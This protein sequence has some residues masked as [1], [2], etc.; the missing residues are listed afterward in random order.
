MT[1]GQFDVTSTLF[2]VGDVVCCPGNPDIPERK[3]VRVPNA[4]AECRDL[5]LFNPSLCDDELNVFPK[6]WALCDDETSGENRTRGGIWGKEQLSR[7]SKVPPLIVNDYIDPCDPEEPTEPAN[8]CLECEQSS[9]KNLDLEF[10][11]I[12][13]TQIPQKVVDFAM[14]EDQLGEKFTDPP[15]LLIPGNGT[16]YAGIKKAR[17]NLCCLGDKFTNYFRVYNRVG[18]VPG[19]TEVSFGHVEKTFDV[20]QNTIIEFYYLYEGPIDPDTSSSNKPGAV[21]VGAQLG[22]SSK[23]PSFN[24]G[25]NNVIDRLYMY[26]PPSTNLTQPTPPL[27]VDNP[28]LG[29]N[30]LTNNPSF[31]PFFTDI[32][33]ICIQIGK[34]LTTQQW[35]TYRLNR[36]TDSSY[37]TDNGTGFSE[38]NLKNILKPYYTTKSKGSGLGLSIVN[39][40]IND[41]EGT[42]E[43]KKQDVGAKII[44]KLPKNV[45]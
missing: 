12:P 27:I 30:I 11:D 39:K 19:T 29:S 21:G 24:G 14:R 13:I 40:I 32:E 23:V 38:I 20:T 25:R 8:A 4:G 2:M 34:K 16:G 15:S 9:S 35:G 45:D 44:V 28:M 5:E 18:K 1:Y 22:G 31:T 41:H 37:L 26:I 17:I 7:P 3:W 10:Y 33:E 36:T 6:C 42:I 43:F